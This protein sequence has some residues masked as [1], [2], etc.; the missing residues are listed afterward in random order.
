MKLQRL[1]VDI[2][3]QATRMNRA[4]A[5]KRYLVTDLEIIAEMAT[6]A[7]AELKNMK[8]SNE[9]VN[10]D[11]TMQYEPLSTVVREGVINDPEYKRY[12]DYY[13]FTDVDSDKNIMGF[14]LWKSFGS[15]I[16]R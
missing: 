2:E 13:K 4:S 16:C 1:L 11:K 15:S 14:C 7:Q 6:K 9:N 3:E 8:E 10:T 5:L 12:C